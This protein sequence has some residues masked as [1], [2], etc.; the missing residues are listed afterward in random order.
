[1]T[2][3]QTS[4]L[5]AGLAVM[6]LL[7]RVLRALARCF[8]QP[9]VLGVVV[10]GTALGPTLFHGAVSDALF[11]SST[12]PLLSALAAVG[13]AVFMLIVGRNGTRP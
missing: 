8:G 3:E 7:A 5:Q 11:P 10:A 12:W 4:S 6:V 13:V 2:T 9:P 1:M